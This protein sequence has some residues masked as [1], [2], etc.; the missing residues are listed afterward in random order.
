MKYSRSKKMI[1]AAALVLTGFGVGTV[2]S[3]AGAIPR[4]RPSTGEN[5]RPGN[6]DQLQ[7]LIRPGGNIYKAAPGCGAP[8]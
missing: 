2:S 4:P 5:H 3:T 8:I 7:C 6:L 1:A